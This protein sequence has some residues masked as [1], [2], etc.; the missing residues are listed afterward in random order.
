MQKMSTPGLAPD[1]CYID[2]SDIVVLVMRGEHTPAKDILTTRTLREG[3][4]IVRA[5]GKPVRIMLDMM[6]V[7]KMGPT[8]RFKGFT[9][10]MWIKNCKIAFIINEHSIVGQFVLLCRNIVDLKRYCNF[11]NEAD[12]RTWLLGDD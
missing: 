9:N 12:A 8:A 5:E 6:Q 7:T 3:I 2:D 10:I 11:A 4:D 1:E